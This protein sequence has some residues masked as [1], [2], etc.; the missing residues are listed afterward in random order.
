MGGT[1]HALGTAVWWSGKSTAKHMYYHLIII[2]VTVTDIN[3]VKTFDI[4]IL[5]V[6]HWQIH[7]LSSHQFK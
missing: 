2:L 3:N 7:D 5:N 4:P 6:L 1:P